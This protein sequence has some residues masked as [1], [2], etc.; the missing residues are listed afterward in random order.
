MRKTKEEALITREKLL[1]A[2]LHLFSQKGFTA[3]RLEDIA[4][5]VGVTRGAIYHHF[6][7]K[8]D[9][10]IALVTEREAGVNRLAGEIIAEGGTPAVI[11]RRLLVGLFEYLE[12]NEEYRALL[13]LAVNKVELTEELETYTEQVLQGRRMLVKSLENL[14]Q[15]GVDA[16]DFRHDLPTYDAALAMSG[17]MNGIGLIW[18]QDP[19]SFSI[20]N[21]A[22]QLVDVFLK[23]FLP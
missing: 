20:G 19:D 7:S 21:R 2:A 16:G 12:N 15:Q 14:I 8:E 4:Q 9:L 11:L 18:V 5:A 1:S 17:F 22:E 10:F 13:E 3:T 23:G 6:G